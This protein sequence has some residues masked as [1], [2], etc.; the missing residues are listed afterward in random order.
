MGLREIRKGVHIKPDMLS[1]LRLPVLLSIG[2][3][4]LIKRLRRQ[5][6]HLTLFGDA[7]EAVEDPPGQ[8]KGEHKIGK[9]GPDHAKAAHAPVITKEPGRRGHPFAVVIM[10]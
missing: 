3:K 7:K 1:L 10:L 9:P 8:N 2:P 6:R 5:K 4:G